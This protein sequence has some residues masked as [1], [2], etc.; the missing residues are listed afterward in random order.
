MASTDLLLD[1][2]VRKALVDGVCPYVLTGG[3]RAEREASE[4][5]WDMLMDRVKSKEKQEQEETKNG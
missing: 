1:D 3:F 2:G 5:T 4:R